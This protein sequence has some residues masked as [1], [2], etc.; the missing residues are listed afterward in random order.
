MIYL[1][2]AA[3][4]KPHKEVLDSFVKVNESVYYNPNSPHKMGLQAEKVLNQAK[5]R[6]NQLLFGKQL[7]D[8]IFTSGATESNNIALKGVA[9]RKKQFANEIITSVLEHPSVLEVMRYLETQ[10]FVLK[11]VNVKE[12]GQI[13]MDHLAS[14]MN[15]KVGLVT[16]MYVNNIMG[17]IQP[18]DQ[19]VELLKQYPKAH[20]HVDAVQAL[21][22]VPMTLTGVNSVSFSGH[23]FNGLKGQGLL[24]IDNKEKLEPIVHG[25]GQE[26]GVRSGTVNLAMDVSLVKAIDLAVSN[27]D[28]RHT[29][30]ASF[31]EDLRSFFKDY[32]GVY[33]NSPENGAPQILN[34][35]FPGVKGEVLVNAFSKLDIMV[36]TTSACSSKR[37]K[38]NE[39]LLAMNI[40]EDKIEGSIRLSLGDT[41]TQEDINQFKEKFE[42]IYTEVKELLK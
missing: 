38:L 11:Y 29:K 31:N 24:L 13:D 3:T 8:V 19:I 33:I 34:I 36:S 21:G 22:K 20:L 10:G 2:N 39:V 1:D 30:L 27:L 6:I 37:G 17:Q 7:Y 4:T 26:Y 41:T 18:I 25:G 16:C 12:N 9:L 35:A 15:D 40:N 23:K 28:E 42:T 5:E 14:L 32:K